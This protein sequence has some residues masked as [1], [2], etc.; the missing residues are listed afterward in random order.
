[1]KTRKKE[2]REKRVEKLT[3][4]FNYCSQK[5]TTDETKAALASVIDKDYKKTE[6]ALEKA[7]IL[8][9]I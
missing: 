9:K 5:L 6:E 4:I 3:G 7:G 1:M 2:T 8:I